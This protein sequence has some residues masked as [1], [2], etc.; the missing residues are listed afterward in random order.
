MDT[1]A[2]ATD[3]PSRIL[4]AAENLIIARGGFQR[5]RGDA[6]GDDEVFCRI[7]DACGRINGGG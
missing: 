3:A 2:P 1:H 5:Q 7:E 4:D 6:A